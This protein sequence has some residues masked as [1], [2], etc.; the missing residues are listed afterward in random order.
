[1]SFLF[2]SFFGPVQYHTAAPIAN[3]FA[4]EIRKRKPDR[5]GV[6]GFPDQKPQIFEY[7]RSSSRMKQSGLISLV[8]NA[9]RMVSAGVYFAP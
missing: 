5:G 4:K 8:P 2:R 7:L 6:I 1:M 9:L 3:L